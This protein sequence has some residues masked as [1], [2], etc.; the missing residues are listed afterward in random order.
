MIMGGSEIELSAGSRTQRLVTLFIPKQ[1]LAGHYQVTYHIQALDAP[2]TTHSGT[3][4]LVVRAY[5][6]LHWEAGSLPPFLVAATSYTL[7]YNLHNDSNVESVVQLYMDV[8]PRSVEQD[9]LTLRLAPGERRDVPVTVHTEDVQHR[10]RH[11]IHLRAVAADTVAADIR[12]R[13]DVYPRLKE[14]ELSYHRFPLKLTSGSS[15]ISD[16]GETTTSYQYKLEGEGTLIPESDTELRFVLQGPR[17]SSFSGF[18]QFT[19]RDRYYAHLTNERLSARLGDQS[20]RGLGVTPGSNGFG[21]NLKYDFGFLNAQAYYLDSRRPFETGRDLGGRLG[22]GGTAASLQAEYKKSSDDPFLDGRTWTA[23]GRLTP[24]P[25]MDLRASGATSSSDVFGNG[26]AYDMSGAYRGD[27]FGVSVEHEVLDD[28]F[29]SWVRGATRSSGFVYY[30]PWT[31]WGIQSRYART[32]RAGNVQDQLRGSLSLG[33]HVE[34]FYE[35][36][37][38]DRYW[39]EDHLQAWE[40]TV[41]ASLSTR[42]RTV[43]FGAE[44]QVGRVQDNQTS[45]SPLNTEYRL[46]G[47]WKPSQGIRI[48]TLGSHRNG[49]S[50]YS[51][52]PSTQSNAQLQLSFGLSPRARLQLSGSYDRFE[53]QSFVSHSHRASTDFT[54]TFDSGT[55]LQLSGARRQFG[56]RISYG[57]G[58]QLSQAIGVPLRRDQRTGLVQGRVVDS[59]TGKGIPDVPI[60]LDNAAVLT[61]ENGLFFISDQPP[62]RHLLTVDVQALPAGHRIAE[63][64]PYEVV[65]YGG[66]V[67]EVSLT[68]RPSASIRGTVYRKAGDAIQRSTGREDASPHPFAGALLELEGLTSSGRE[69]YQRRLTDSEGTFRILGLMAG[70]YE[71]RLLKSSL[72]EYHQAS[73]ET[74]SLEVQDGDTLD[75][76]F[77]VRPVQRKIEFLEVGDR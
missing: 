17:P 29:L 65:V 40:N 15:S 56:E 30:R 27:I 41:G 64:L 20:A 37:G 59:R 52:S 11:P 21:A 63:E 77:I 19:S 5:Q 31:G 8:S 67:T 73:P 76:S 23:E 50:V 57:V 60:R 22:I 62:G 35:G 47:Y 33:P 74:I 1:A 7:P 68:S 14:A 46:Y 12:T 6:N 2:G 3:L 13:L 39:Q 28:Q 51:S 66:E 71:L 58:I 53:T 44:T 10:Y 36:V 45:T 26:R 48:G 43:S 75:V 4:P 72:P 38:L 34:L 16:A 25:R 24:L 18:S 70:T 69:V 54:Y 61:N 49:R 32:Q 55:A 42:G 9:S